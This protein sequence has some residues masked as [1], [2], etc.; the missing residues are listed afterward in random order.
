MKHI[1]R[2][3][4]QSDAYRRAS[5]GSLD[6][7]QA[8]R[9]RDP[10]NRYYWRFDVRRLDAEEVRD[11]VLLASGLLDTSLGDQISVKPTRE[12]HA[13]LPVLSTCV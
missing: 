10:D 13:T 7:I 4:L 12:D 1:H 2:L 11:G 8:A 5:S 3:I 9:E 6:R